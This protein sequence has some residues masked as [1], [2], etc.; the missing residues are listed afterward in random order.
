MNPVRRRI[1]RRASLKNNE[2]PFKPSFHQNQR[3]FL[4]FIG[5]SKSKETGDHL[6]QQPESQF[7][8]PFNDTAYQLHPTI[9]FVFHV[10]PLHQCSNSPIK[11]LT[12]PLTRYLISLS[13]P[14]SMVLPKSNNASCRSNYH[15]S[16]RVLADFFGSAFVSW[17]PNIWY[18]KVI[19]TGDAGWHLQKE[20][21][22]LRAC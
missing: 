17:R 4:S 14:W 1:R 6:E 19:T 20:R 12:P 9:V 8:Q 22:F 11:I 2:P 10:F 16:S 15:R 13:A 21:F 7:K 18:A 3:S 5:L